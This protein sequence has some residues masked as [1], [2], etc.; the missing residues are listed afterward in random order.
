MSKSKNLTKRNNDF[1]VEIIE[2]GFVLS[3]GGLDSDD[4]WINTRV[5]CNSE[6]SLFK[7]IS[8]FVN[9]QEQG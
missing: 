1:S 4:N 2:N 7:I 6:E 3:L 9:L 8:G 5:H